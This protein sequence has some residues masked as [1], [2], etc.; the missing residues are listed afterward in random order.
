[1]GFDDLSKHKIWNTLRWMRALCSTILSALCERCEQ[2]YYQVVTWHGTHIF[3]VNENNFFSTVFNQQSSSVYLHSTWIFT[4][5]VLRMYAMPCHDPLYSTLIAL[6][7]MKNTNTIAH[8]Y[9][10][11]MFTQHFI[12]SYVF[13]F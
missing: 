3:K 11:I 7:E 10:Q 2:N 12:T 5:D 6:N 8:H 9:K 4:I 1:M 13:R